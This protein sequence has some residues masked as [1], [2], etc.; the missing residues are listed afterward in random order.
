MN[1]FTEVSKRNKLK[2]AL[3]GSSFISLIEKGGDFSQSKPV[4]IS[5]YI[6]EG[7]YLRLSLV[8]VFLVGTNR[9]LTSSGLLTSYWILKRNEEEL[10]LNINV[11][12]AYYSVD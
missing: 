12:K 11:E 2:E 4:H 9:F 1:M 3:N 5:Y 7:T 6:S 10:I 8:K